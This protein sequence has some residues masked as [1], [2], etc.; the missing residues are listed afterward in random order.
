MD[1]ILLTQSRST[2]KHAKVM[3]K[4]WSQIGYLVAVGLLI[5]SFVVNQ[6]SNSSVEELMWIKPLVVD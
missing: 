5:F 4:R 2:E 1:S 6:E 3:V